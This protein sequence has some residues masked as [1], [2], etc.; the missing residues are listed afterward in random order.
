MAQLPALDVPTIGAAKGAPGWRVSV[1]RGSPTCDGASLADD[2]ELRVG[3]WIETR[4]TDEARLA[5]GSIGELRLGPESRLRLLSNDPEEHRVKLERGSIHAFVDAPPRMFLVDT[6]VTTAVDLGC[7]YK[8]DVLADG[9][10]SLSVATGWV[11][12]ESAGQAPTYVPAGF[13]AVTSAAG[14][15]SLPWRT[16]AEAALIAAVTGF[17][18]DDPPALTR[19][20]SALGADDLPTAWHLL[21]VDTARA[22][23][24]ERML[25]LGAPRPSDPAPIS[26]GDAS[27]LKH[28]GEQLGV[29]P[30]P[31]WPAP[32]PSDHGPP[33]RPAPVWSPND[34][35]PDAS[36]H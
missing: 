11:A 16:D 7:E 6:P 2:G 35:S 19:L 33:D 3:G 23:V 20:L 28:W 9:A 31:G 22:R 27:A 17:D 1:L 25:A 18:R 21:A 12:L 10:I 4:T 34:A 24:F 29:A 36:T 26:S 32:S 8:L 5:I 30:P 13:S 15:A 14:R